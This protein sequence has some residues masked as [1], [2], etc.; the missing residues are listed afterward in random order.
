MYYVY[1]TDVA[2][3][4]AKGMDYQGTQKVFNVGSGL[5]YSLNEILT[6]CQK[7]SQKT[8]TINYLEGRSFDVPI[9][10]LSIQKAQEK[11]D[12][13]PNISIEEGVQATWDWLMKMG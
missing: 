13:H 10:I 2:Q 3:I 8:P 4:I 6:V 9:N 7:V 5:G 1:V 12:W 11:L